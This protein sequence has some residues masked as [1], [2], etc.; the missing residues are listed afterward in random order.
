VSRDDI[1]A[2]LERYARAVLE[3]DVGAF[4]SLYHADVRVFDAWGHWACDGLHAWRQMARAWFDSLGR[5]RVAVSPENL[6]IEVSGELASVS[7]MLTYTALAPGGEPV[8]SMR[9]RL[10]W[11]LRERDGAWK[12]VHEHTSVPLDFETKAMLRDG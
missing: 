1:A 6:S 4:A 3:K 11:V 10:T 12:V 9:N 8:R 2:V 5:E 7:G